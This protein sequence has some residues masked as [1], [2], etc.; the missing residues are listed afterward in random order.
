MTKGKSLLAL[1]GVTFFYAAVFGGLAYSAKTDPV[2]REP[3][4]GVDIG[5]VGHE[6][7]YGAV[8]GIVIPPFRD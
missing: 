5:I 7:A 3:S 1:I 2:G 8:H 6:S 4:V